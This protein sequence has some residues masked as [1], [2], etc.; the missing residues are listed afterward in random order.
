MPRKR[1]PARLVYR[2]RKG[3][4][5]RWIIVDGG[6]KIDTGCGNGDRSRAE[7]MLG[8]YIAARRKIDTSER[9]PAQISCADVIALYIK[10][11]P[12]PPGCYHAGPLLEFFGLKTLADITGA[13]CRDYSARRGAA[14]TKSTVRR[15]L[16][17]L[18]AAINFWHQESPLSAVPVV[19][20]PDESL[21]RLRYLTRR[22]AARLLAASRR[23]KA[24]HI[25]R[26][27]LIGIYTGTRHA[28][29]LGLRWQP[30]QDAGWIDVQRGILHRAGESEQQT[31]KRRPASR[32]P[33]RLLA[34]LRRWHARDMAAGPQTAIIRWR[35]MPIRK[36][37]RAW[38]RV[39]TAAKLGD[40]VTPHVLKHTCATWALQSKMSIWDL[41][42]LMGT[43]VKTIEA[44][45]GHHDPEFQTGVAGAFRR[46]G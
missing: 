17:T 41:A 28:A 42:G 29:I 27:I 9:N 6:K 3:R 8:E 11:N 20:K 21:P 30:S 35:G 10:H 23:L 39:R 31:R 26:F 43:S 16:G 25:S 12:A 22:D 5:G 13:L 36:E 15:E 40:D 34:H 2:Q 46:A 1:L 44:T 7:E 18:Q 45:Y 37:R 14:V 19:V 33:D 24:R 38:D 4:E 32:V